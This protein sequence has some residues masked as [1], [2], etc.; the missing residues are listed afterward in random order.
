MIP[1]LAAARQACQEI[2][3]MSLQTT[4]L[5]W[6]VDGEAALARLMT[7]RMRAPGEEADAV[8]VA[9]ADEFGILHQ[10]EPVRR[11]S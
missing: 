3:L 8:L 10:S 11:V 2:D 4:L 1:S 9:V 7:V 5:T 6:S